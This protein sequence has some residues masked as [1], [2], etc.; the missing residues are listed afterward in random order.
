M[1]MS[2][3]IER[4]EAAENYCI[5]WA[6]PHGTPDA[7]ISKYA[8]SAGWDACAK[9]K[10]VF[11]LVEALNF[12]AWAR[13]FKEPESWDYFGQGGHPEI[14]DCEECSAVAGDALAQFKREMER[15]R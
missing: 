13:V 9:S 15:R 10:A 12:Y 6:I 7:T 8:F 1:L 3:S 11:G 4:D 2:N 5:D 14:V